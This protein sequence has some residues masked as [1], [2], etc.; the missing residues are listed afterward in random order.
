MTDK[1]LVLLS[2]ALLLGCGPGHVTGS[3]GA[4]GETGRDQ[5]PVFCVDPSTSVITCWVSWGD[6]YAQAW[7]ECM[8]DGALEAGVLGEGESADLGTWGA[9]VCHP[10]ASTDH[11]IC[12]LE[13]L[14]VV[15]TDTSGEWEPVTNDLAADLDLVPWP[16]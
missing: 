2:I 13:P 15:L 12:F 10:L 14:G 8:V 4:S 9:G 3:V 16:C 1:P 5:A 6:T 11:T 7:P